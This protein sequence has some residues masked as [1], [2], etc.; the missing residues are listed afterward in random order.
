VRRV[1]RG[2]LGLLLFDT[3]DVPGLRCAHSLAPLDVRQAGERSRFVAAAGLDPERVASPAQ[4]HGADVA[5]VDAP[6]AR[7]IEADGLVTATPGLALLVKAADCSLIVVADPV[8][9]AVGVAHAGWRGAAAG[10]V[11]NLVAALVREFGC[12]P[13]DMLGAVGPTIGVLRYAVGGEVLDA[14]RRRVP[15]AGDHART[16]DG[17]LHYDVAGANGRALVECGVARVEVAGICTH[18]RPDMLFSYRRQGAGAG[19]HG[20][21]AAWA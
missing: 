10:V 4:V 12:A 13:R 5:R 11:E 19:H 6:P 2:S 3:L 9:R 15:W 7:A 1:A 14:F 21:V 20:L 16:I 8:R 18:D 17:R